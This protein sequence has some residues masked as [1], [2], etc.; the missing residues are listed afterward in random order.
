MRV[1]TNKIEDP[2]IKKST[3]SKINGT[4]E[5]SLLKLIGEITLLF[6]ECLGEVA[7]SFFKKK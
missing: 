6:T 2:P 1:P 3:D 7:V 4:N 5:E